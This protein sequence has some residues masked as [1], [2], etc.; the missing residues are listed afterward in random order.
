MC[1]NVVLCGNGLI[2]Q[3]CLT[4]SQMTNF[5]LF[6]T[7]TFADDNLNICQ[8]MELVFPTIENIVRKEKMLAFKR[9]L[10]QGCENS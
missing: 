3:K 8:M 6:Q 10:F 7:K 1:Q 5:L 9:L 4:L 2:F